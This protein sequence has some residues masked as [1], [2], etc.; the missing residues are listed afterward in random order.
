MARHR[1][2]TWVREVIG[3]TWEYHGITGGGH[4]RL[5]H[6]PSGRFAIVAATPSDRRTLAN[7]RALLRRIERD[8]EGQGGDAVP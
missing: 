3:P 2:P 6:A 1:A 4:V 8:H 5:V 7:V